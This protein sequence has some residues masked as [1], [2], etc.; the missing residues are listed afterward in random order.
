MSEKQ[1]GNKYQGTCE[2]INITHDPGSLSSA[3]P[4]IMGQD[5]SLHQNLFYSDNIK[6]STLNLIALTSFQLSPS[7][8]K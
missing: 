3:S 1:N 8:T 5:I 4:T 7:S 2:V 6:I